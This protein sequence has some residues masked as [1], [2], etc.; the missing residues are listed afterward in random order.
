M[1]FESSN[2]QIRLPKKAERVKNKAAAPLQITAE[3]LLR[4]AKEREL[5]IV[6]RAPRVRVNDPEEAAEQA[7]KKRK[8]FEDNIRKNRN[9]IANWIK[10][11][12]WE[13]S[14]GEIERSRSVFERGLDVDH[15]NITIWLQYAEMEMRN[16][17]INHARNIWD[18]A[19]QILP[20]ATQF[21][22]KYTYMEELVENIPGARQVFERWMEW[23]PNE[24]A[25][26]TYINFELRYKEIDRSRDI[27]QR[28]LHVH[29]HDYK[30]WVRYARFEE[31]FGYAGNARAAFE[32]AIE[33]FGDDNLD[34]QLLVQFAK[35]EERQ[36]EV[37]RARAIYQYG[38]DRL[39][40]SKS[41]G[42][43]DGLA[44]HE[45]KYGEQLR[46]ENVIVS[47]RK[48]KYE[49]QLAHNSY[50]YDT[51]FD[52]VNLLMNEQVS[53]EE[54]EDVYERAIANI[55]PYEEK[56]YWR[57]YIYLWIYYAVYE[58]LDCEDIERAR[59]VFKAC[60]DVIPHKKFTFAKI[61]IMFSQFEIRQLELT[62]AR[63]IMGN[64]IGKCPKKKLFSSYIDMELRFR[65]FDR[66]RTLYEK[67][68]LFAPDNSST[69]IKFAELETIL[70]DVDRAR[71]IFN[72]AIQ[73]PALDMPEVL[74]KAY[75]DFEIEQEEN[76]HV[77]RLY[78]TLLERTN[79]IKVWISWTEFEVR[80]EAFDKARATFK[81]ANDSL[82][83]SPA[84]ERILLLETWLEFERTHGNEEEQT[85]VEKLMPK[86]VKKRRPILA[87]DGTDAG[88]E[89]YYDYIFPQDQAS[90]V[91]FK[92]LE[93]ARLWREKQ[94]AQK[95]NAIP[96]D[97]D[98]E[99]ELPSVS[100]QLEGSDDYEA[101]KRAR[102]EDGRGD[103]DSDVEMSSSSSSED[104]EEEER[105][106]ESESD[107][108]SD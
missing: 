38:L 49:D 67:L 102:G 13:E 14:I 26:Q 29:G 79:H 96:V 101:V 74:W 9:Q 6:P 24:Q 34:E 56:R 41:K 19:V 36:K 88:W 1:D 58:E 53:R 98:A 46:I 66:C 47:K 55:P 68:V 85:A 99:S 75:I 104:E 25:W 48:R 84:E 37:E 44:I 80:I 12:K 93:A 92:L 52:Y 62:Q 95:E 21:W 91:S 10:Y 31:R 71:A 54:V 89:E 77:R 90:K 17:Q 81:R 100:E 32:A 22:L 57:R 45:K 69:W 35:F 97:R 27:Y 70:G 5:E 82:E 7:R 106:R 65:E 86:R 15:R 23:E 4:E 78:E 108:K 61:W 40:S 43:F 94:A 59:D 28:F 72:M 103:E 11:A 30:N 42:I 2:K 20:R 33:F 50:D 8:E 73:Q 3:Q 64:A 105:Q 39:P 16:K 51:W 60:L 83:S 107:G 18:R 87:E 76:D 63:K